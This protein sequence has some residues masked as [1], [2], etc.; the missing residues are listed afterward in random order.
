MNIIYYVIILD[1]IKINK[2][3]FTK[4]KYFKIYL[5]NYKLIII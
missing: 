5:N 3:Y 4:N 2:Y 1:K